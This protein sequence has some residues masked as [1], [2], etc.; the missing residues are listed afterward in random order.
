MLTTLSAHYT[1]GEFERFLQSLRFLDTFDFARFLEK[2]SKL[3]HLLTE[4]TAG[5]FSASTPETKQLYRDA[6]IRYAHKHRLSE[7]A[8]A[9]RLGAR[10]SPLVTHRKAG[11]LSL[12]LQWLITIMISI[13]VGLFTDQ[14]LLAFLL[15][16]P[17]SELCKRIV[18][19]VFARLFPAV[20]LPRLDLKQIPAQAKSLVVITALLTGGSGDQ[21]L[22]DRLERFFLANR[23]ENL[24]FGLLCD[25][26]D[27]KTEHTEKD[28]QLLSSVQAS[29]DKQLEW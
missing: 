10:V 11:I 20:P 23:D 21:Q 14:I 9:E 18:D 27:S 22:V 19:D 28:A 3:E 6:V 29:L 8:A 12:C 13:I 16:L 17:I 26:P 1:E 2:H 5:V 7:I 4:N 25:Y 15:F 24:R